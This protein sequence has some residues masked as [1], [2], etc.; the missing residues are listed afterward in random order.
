MI[1]VVYIFIFILCGDR[2]SNR[3]FGYDLSWIWKFWINIWI[4]FV[5]KVLWIWG[6]VKKIWK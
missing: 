5:G 3:R 2:F 6:F 4:G 1:Y